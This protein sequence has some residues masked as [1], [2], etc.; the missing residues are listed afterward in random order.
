MKFYYLIGIMMYWFKDDF[1]RWINLS[2]VVT[3]GIDLNNEKYNVYAWIPSIEKIEKFLI[4]KSCDSEIEAQSYID[5]I[6]ENKKIKPISRC[7]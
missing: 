7:C 6:I 2:M 3:L 4:L 1:N 5:N